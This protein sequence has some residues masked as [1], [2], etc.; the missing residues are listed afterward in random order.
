MNQE[1]NV[2]NRKS[3]YVVWIIPV[4]AMIIA[5][6]MIFKYYDNI[7]YDISITFDNGDGIS[8]GKTP[9]MYNGIKIGKV[10]DIHIHPGDISKVDVTITVD[11]IAEGV[12]R[13]GNIFWKVSPKLSLTEVT[14]LSTILSG[15]YIGVMPSVKDPKDLIK[16]P[17]KD[18]FIANTK[19]PIDIFDAGKIIILHSDNKDVQVGAPVMYRKMD[20]GTVMDVKLTELGVEYSIKVDKEYTHLVKIKSKFWKISGVEVRASLAGLRVKMDSLA[21]LVAGG[22]EFSSP[23]DSKSID[24]NKYEYKLYEEKEKVNLSSEL[25]T[26][27]S[28]SGY[29][30]DIKASHV[31][32]KGSVAGDI[33]KLDYN[34]TTDETTFKVKLKKKFRHLANEDARFWIVEPSIGLTSF[35]GLDAIASGPYISFE[36]HTKTQKLKNRFFLHTTPPFIIGKHFKLIADDSFNLKDGVNVIYRNIIIGSLRKSKLA[37]DKQSVEFDIVIVDKYKNIVNNSSSFYIEDAVDFDASFEGVHLNIGSISSVVNGGIVLHTSNL[38]APK[39]ATTFELLKNYK[40]FKNNIYISDGGKEFTLIS[41]DLNSIK[42]GSYILYKGIK[43]G[44]VRSYKLDKK[45]SKIKV[46]IYIKKEYSDLVNSSTNFFNISGI[47]VNADLNGVKIKTGSIES[48]VNGGISFKTPLKVNKVKNMHE[49]ILYKDED[50]VDGKYVDITFL[51]KEDTGLKIG[52]SIV[53]KSIGIGQ[54][55]DM[56]LVDDEVILKALIKEEYK[57]LLA[58][59]TKFWIEDVSI[60]MDGMKN[61][62]AILSGAFIKLLRGHKDIKSYKFN[63]SK[64]PPVA[65]INKKGLRVVVYASRL[66]SL[67]IGSPVFYRQIKIGSVEAYK[68]SDNSK[69]VELKLFIDEC[70]S[71]LV[72]NNSI[73]YNATALGMD[74]SLFGVKIKTETLATMIKGG[75]TMVTPDTP[76]EKAQELEEF[77]LY[78]EVEEDWLK[79]KAELINDVSTCREEI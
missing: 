50:A 7:G 48:I 2:K 23:I 27:V 42:I 32:F 51:A 53:Y 26:L 68:L 75:I 77:K 11:K 18:K 5:G 13:E 19:A 71:Y 78:D 10:S 24:S 63:I 43:V 36:T 58:K 29:N 15:V 40:T 8:V 74:I 61:S 39:T 62:S 45:T 41:D 4:L 55:S 60:G 65:T 30:I 37:K 14:G 52:S 44:K 20:V 17:F 66:S 54:I 16:L 22:I 35:K 70:Y 47:E 46:N 6:W 3:I 1:A 79:Y 73:F 64:T 28:R 34:P 38:S 9:L 31:F 72:R 59:D 25:I 76:E 56:K 33:V 57:D 21:S 49:F 67:K 69:D 12:A